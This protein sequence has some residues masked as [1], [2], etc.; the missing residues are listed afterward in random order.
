MPQLACKE[1]RDDH[2]DHER[3]ESGQDRCGAQLDAGT[4]CA[5]DDSV[6]DADCFCA[7]IEHDRLTY[8]CIVAAY[9]WPMKTA[10]VR[11]D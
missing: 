5:K 3:R 7:I 1:L 9:R 4:V 6:Q 10:N 11:P 8:C 2:Q